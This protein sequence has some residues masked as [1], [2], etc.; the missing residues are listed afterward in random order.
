MTRD[1][2]AIQGMFDLYKSAMDNKIP[3]TAAEAWPKLPTGKSSEEH[4]RS[5]YGVRPL[6]FS[7]SDV[8]ASGCSV[9]VAIRP[10][11]ATL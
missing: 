2:R 3:V 6:P 10:M 11:K 5:R 4:G 1:V 8:G 9:T 7:Q